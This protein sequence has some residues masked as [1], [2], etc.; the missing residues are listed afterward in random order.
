MIHLAPRERE[1]IVDSSPPTP[2]DDTTYIRFAIEQLTRD[3]DVVGLGRDSSGTDAMP[4]LPVQGIGYAQSKKS[5]EL[6]KGLAAAR[7]E[8]AALEAAG[9]PLSQ[10]RPA[11]SRKLGTKDA[12]AV[13]KK[14]EAKRY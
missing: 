12:N 7:K 9:L 6:R 14:T 1:L 4:L 13:M 3:E 10:T 5:E 2:T 8:R 11:A